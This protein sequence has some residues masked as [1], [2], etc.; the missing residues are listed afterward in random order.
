MF[1]MLSNPGLDSKNVNS[2]S[3][4]LSVENTISS[5]PSR[6]YNKYYSKKLV[7]MWCAVAGGLLFIRSRSLEIVKAGAENFQL[8]IS[9]L[10]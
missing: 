9:M 8:D 1:M 2:S 3:I 7:S 5:A 10:I 6:I 4:S